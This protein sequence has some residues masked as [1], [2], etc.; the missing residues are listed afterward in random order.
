MSDH[1]RGRPSAQ[2]R[3][4]FAGLRRLHQAARGRLWPLPALGIAV[5]VLA[6]VGLPRLDAELSD[7]LPAWARA[8]LFSGGATSAREVLGASAASL[9][10]VTS[11]TFSLTV[12]TLQLASGQFSPR[13]L[14]TFVRD[15]TVQATLTLFL[16]TFTY[17]LTVLRTVRGGEGV[18]REFVPQVSVTLAALLTLASVLGL[19]MF[20]AHLAREIRVESML[21]AVH[22]DAVATL[23]RH[24]VERS[25]DG[26]D[27][28]LSEEP[29]SGAAHLISARSGFL[30]EIDGDAAVTAACELDAIVVVDAPPGSSTIAGTPYGRVWRRD[31]ADLSE[32]DVDRMQQAMGAAVRTGF[33]RTDAQDV[34]F[35]L[36]QLVDVVTKA[37]SPGINDPTTAVHALSH[38][39]ALLCALAGRELGPA[40]LRDEDGQVRVVL[41]RP[42]LSDHLEVALTQPRIYGAGDPVVLARL[43]TLLREV[44]WVARDATD[45]AAV[46][47][48]LGRL[49]QAV[50]QR[51]YAGEERERFD[52]L[53]A[54][55]ESALERQWPVEPR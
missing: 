25:D 37:L 53:G 8:Y 45:R 3:T 9:I 18:D 29:S 7:S 35:A 22:R 17:A 48:Q 1:P 26:S 30:I 46:R 43:F 52:Q 32:R 24:T 19:V 40:R 55:V 34:G 36:R 38:V 27:D 50:Q 42:N 13:L 21:R 6:G 51:G 41:R 16:A 47:R 11:L 12:L 10:T 54:F 4:G 39:S 44:G 23:H 15:R 31:G 49:R 33:E 14:R 20:L 2:S 28:A 5:A